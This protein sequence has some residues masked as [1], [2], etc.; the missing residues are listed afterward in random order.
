MAPYCYGL[1]Q[2]V[3]WSDSLRHQEVALKKVHSKHF[4][5]RIEVARENANKIPRQHDA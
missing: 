1:T 4:L 2:A 5:F 3:L